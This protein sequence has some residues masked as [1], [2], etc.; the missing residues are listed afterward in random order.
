MLNFD[1]GKLAKGA[2]QGLEKAEKLGGGAGDAAKSVLQ[3]VKKV[4]NLAELTEKAPEQVIAVLRKLL[5]EAKQL[6]DSL[7]SRNEALDN[8]IQ[9]AQTLLDSGDASADAVAK[10]TA[11]LSALM[12]GAG[13]PAA[14]EPQKSVPTPSAPAAAAPVRAAPAAEAP[15]PKKTVQFSDVKADAYYYEAVQWAVQKG[16][17]SGTTETTFSPDQTCTRA[18]TIT[19]LWRANGSPAPKSKD[20][21]FTDVKETA[22]YHDALLWAAEQGIVSGGTFHPDDATTRGQLAE[23]LY[24]SAGSPAVAEGS[25]FGDVSKDAAYSKAVAWVAKQGI[26]SGTGENTFSPDRACTRGQIVTFLYRAKK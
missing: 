16:I 17:A 13:Q 2:I 10:L 8:C 25:A 11:E 22:Y 4:E 24:K 18:Q 21:P 14:A 12:K 7:P 19:L 5:E 26:T 15:A 9:K 23:F 3:G 6:A 1:A 20:D